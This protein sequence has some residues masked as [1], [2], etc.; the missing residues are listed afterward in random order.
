MSQP[1]SP[2]GS[3]EFIVKF[4]SMQGTFV[5]ALK[6]AMKD[7]E[8]E[9]GADPQLTSKIDEILQNLRSRL[10]GIWTGNREQFLTTAP[11]D[12]LNNQNIETIK[13]VARDVII[14]QGVLPK[15]EGETKEEYQAKAES[16]AKKYL[17]NW[18]LMIQNAIDDKGNW[19]KMKDRLITHQGS[20]QSGLNLGRLGS[21]AR[22][23]FRQIIGEFL[24]EKEF[25]KKAKEE[26]F[27]L[28]RQKLMAPTPIVIDLTEGPGEKKEIVDWLELA[29]ALSKRGIIKSEMDK[30]MGL[31]PGGGL[32]KGTNIET[33]AI[34][35]LKDYVIAKDAN[36]PNIFL[37][38][39][40]KLKK[41]WTTETFPIG[42]SGVKSDISFSLENTLESEAKFR[43]LYEKSGF[44]PKVIKDM[45]DKAREAF[46]LQKGEPF[47]TKVEGIEV[48]IKYEALDKEAAQK[49]ADDLNKTRILRRGITKMD[50]KEVNKLEK[51]E[52]ELL[53]QTK[54]IKT[55]V[56]STY[57]KFLMFE[58]D[59]KGDPSP[60]DIA[61][62]KSKYS[63]DVEI[64]GFA[65]SQNLIEAE[66]KVR[67]AK[68]TL[69]I[70]EKNKI[71]EGIQ[72]MQE[73]GRMLKEAFDTGNVDLI[74]AF[75]TMLASLT[76]EERSKL[77]NG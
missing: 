8:I 21:R 62:V 33:A 18:N 46:G 77:F 19:E 28:I 48:E 59:F 38:T 27:P 35:L 39:W 58:R 12:I 40:R 25:V 41:E 29:D 49:L 30:A 60:T 37:H 43:R 3:V 63:K 6:E 4:D 71:I 47:G 32:P 22:I 11:A 50:L 14:G 34:D 61:S 69:L 66:K 51:R 9:T 23:A 54:G 52:N 45:I 13:S 17:D 55:I 44:S 68:E 53:E 74:T 24:V 26:E 65:T 42:T 1:A 73:Y 31:K 72:T 16:L 15:E 70:A 36:L 2:I 76:E 5:D 64:I 75:K 10:R 20:I 67:D 56:E 57:Q 7:V